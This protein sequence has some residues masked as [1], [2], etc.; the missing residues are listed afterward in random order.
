MKYFDVIIAGGG[1]MGV[2]TAYRLAREGLEVLVLE[3]TSVGYEASG[4]NAGGVRQQFRDSKETALAIHSVRIWEGLAKELDLDVEYRQGGSLRFALSEA[5]ATSLR[6]A[7]A[8]DQAAGLSVEL[9]KPNEVDRLVPINMEAIRCASYCRTDGHANPTKTTQAFA[10]AARRFGAIIEEATEVTAIT[11]EDSTFLVEA[12][13]TAYRA[14]RVMVAAGPW[15]APLLH[16][17]GVRLPLTPRRP[18][19]AETEPL[20]PFL[21]QFVSLGD[22]KGYGRQTVSGTVH[23][24]IRS[25]DATLEDSE[26]TYE[27]VVRALNEWVALFPQMEGATIRRSWCGFTNWTPDHRPIIGPVP[28]EPG[29]FLCTGFSGHGFALGPGVASVMADFIC[30]R[31]PEI[32]VQPLGLQRFFAEEARSI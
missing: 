25:I 11:R 7:V 27:R 21:K 31:E 19:M 14:V 1:I 20:S 8:Q 22:L 6:Q 28:D 4:R 23:F 2:A 29:L 3:K 18:E 12:G 15:S 9:L 16:P 10:G 13:N 24:G 5:D 30:G 17:F 32:D 26:P